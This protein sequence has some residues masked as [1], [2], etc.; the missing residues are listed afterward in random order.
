M[1]EHV[2][3]VKVKIDPAGGK[4]GLKELDDETKRTASSMKSALGNAVSA[5]MKGAADAAK[6]MLSGIKSVV[7]TAGS[8]LGGL[9]VAEL[10]KGGLDAKSKWSDVTAGIKQAGGTAKDAAAVQA[11]GQKSALAWA[12]DST[13]VADAFDAIRGETGSI[14][15]ATAAIDTVSEAAR[16]AHKNLE[17]VAAVSGTLN[18]KFGITAKELPDALADVVGL[19]AK[20]GVSFEEMSEKL[21]LIGAYAKEA[22]LQGRS[23]LGQIVGMLNLADNANGSFKKGISAVGGLLEQL[24]T[25]AGKNKIGA[26]LGISAKDM[27]GNAAQQIEA[28]MRATKGQKSQLEK[29]F[30]GEQ[31]KLLV[32]LGRTYAASFDATKGTVKEK[33]A[34][35]AAALQQAFATA[36][37]ST[38]SWSDIQAEA[39]AQMNESP[40]KIATATEKLRQAFASDQMQT[41]LGKLIDKLPAFADMLAKFT[42]F[43]AENPG[44]AITGAI[45]A[46]IG[47]AAIGESI[48]SLFKSFPGATLGVGLL[49]AAAVAAAAAIAEYEAA[50][51]KQEE[52]LDETPALIKKAQ[53]EMAA[54]GTVSKDTLDA[55]AQRRAEFEGVKGAGDLTGPAK[56]SYAV[57]LAAKVMGGQQEVGAAEG[58]RVEAQK[59]GAEG[60]NKTIADLDSLIAAAV[61]AKRGGPPAPGLIGGAPAAPG[62]PGAA[63]RAPAGP[64]VDPATMAQLTGNATGQAVKSAL[65][66]QVVRVQIV[67][68]NGPT[69]AGPVTSGAAP[70]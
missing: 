28:V 7:A 65:G 17:G 24:S 21:G 55:L 35:G 67:G 44:T 37:K 33:T 64:A 50:A 1:A 11:Q 8:V 15:F 6:G 45:V 34:A 69:G 52:K 3:A 40:Q 66:S 29:A 26:A 38:V 62:T 60:V 46:N 16:G 25:T 31:L 39:T 59:L 27:G 14:D 13:K 19:S 18:E 30:G 61:A 47:K 32:D 20:G 23:G 43:A 12:Q 22:G 70:R 48:A 68:G 10:V 5:G 36:S 63:P 4:R 53:Q 41:A 57:M 2:A 9:G 51:T 42:T 49:A 56:Q 54:S 58:T